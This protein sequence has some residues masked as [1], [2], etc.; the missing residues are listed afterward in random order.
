MVESDEGRLIEHIKALVGYEELAGDARRVL[1]TL[2]PIKREMDNPETHARYV[3]RVLPYRST[4]DFI[5]GVV[6]TFVDVTA[7]R[8]AK[9]RLRR[10]EER[11]R[12]I[13]ET[14][15]DY[16]IFT[17]DPAGRVETWSPGG[18]QV[19]GWSAEEMVDRPMD[20]AFTPEGRD[21]G[22]PALEEGQAP[23]VRWHLRKK[24][25][26]SSS[27]A[28]CARFWDPTASPPAS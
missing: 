26:A 21:S 24:G 14:A 25:P 8:E 28:W 18:E 10:S 17:T 12:A 23:D 1:R 3:A 27:T 16:A 5:A 20:I 4:D 13:V 6:V 9:E 22:Q 15:S 19:F 11:Y 7:R 2:A